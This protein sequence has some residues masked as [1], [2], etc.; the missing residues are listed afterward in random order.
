LDFVTSDGRQG[1]YFV[2]NAGKPAKTKANPTAFVSV[3]P[4]ATYRLVNERGQNVVVT[5]GTG[6]QGLRD[7]YAAAQR[8]SVEGGTKADWYL[9]RSDQDGQ[10]T[11]I[12]DD[13][14]KGSDLGVAGKI[15]GA[16]LPIATAFIPGLGVLGTIAMQAASGAAGSALAGGDP[17]KGAV[18]GGL[19]A[20]GR[21]RNTTYP[22][23]R[24]SRAS[25]SGAVQ[26][27]PSTSAI[28]CGIGSRSMFRK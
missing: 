23:K 5:T 8:L 27:P 9:E 7:A 3:D 21:S 11:R 14:P 25:A 15:L 2:T 26:S 6:E 24:R 12:A 16:A 13:D 18:V 22:A 17:L 10:W 20:A 28:L 19:T 4:N 1:Y